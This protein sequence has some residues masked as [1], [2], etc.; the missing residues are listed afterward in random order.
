MNF[1]AEGVAITQTSQPATWAS[2]TNG[3]R[4]PAGRPPQAMMYSTRRGRPR[5]AIA[6]LG[7]RHYTDPGR[8]VTQPRCGSAPLT[9]E[10]DHDQLGCYRVVA[11]FLGRKPFGFQECR[12]RGWIISSVSVAAGNVDQVVG[13]SLDQVGGQTGGLDGLGPPQHLPAV[14]EFGCYLH[15]LNRQTGGAEDGM[16]VGMFGPES[17]GRHLRFADKF[18][19]FPAVALASRGDGSR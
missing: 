15:T 17:T 14:A 11:Y 2:S 4:S 19:R 13:A 10:Q 7:L 12:Q 8:Q 9:L 6:L 1:S 3:A 5:A 16:Q 18:P